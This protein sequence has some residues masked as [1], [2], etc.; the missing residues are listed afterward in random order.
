MCGSLAIKMQNGKFY[1]MQWLSGLALAGFSLAPCLSTSGLG[2]GL[3]V[4]SKEKC[5]DRPLSFPS[6]GH[7]GNKRMPNAL[8]ANLQTWRCSET[9]SSSV[10]PH[11]C[12]SVHSCRGYLLMWLFMIG[13]W[14]PI[15]WIPHNFLFC[16]ASSVLFSLGFLFVRLPQALFLF[17]CGALSCMISSLMFAFSS[18]G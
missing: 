3:L 12:L 9:K 4:L 8:K 17:A 18:L 11:G 5:Y 1:G 2:N 10:L 6:F 13:G 14:Y 15:L 7:Y 16:V